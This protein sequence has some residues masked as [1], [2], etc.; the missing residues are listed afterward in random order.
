MT[1]SCQTAYARRTQPRR[2]GPRPSRASRLDELPAC[3]RGAVAWYPAEESIVASLPEGPVS[4]AV[5]REVLDDA[6]RR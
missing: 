6:D 1:L 3:R 4:D 5:L 2:I